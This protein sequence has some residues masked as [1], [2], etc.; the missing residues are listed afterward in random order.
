MRRDIF[1][2]LT[3]ALDTTGHNCF[4]ECFRHSA[5]TRKHSANFFPSVTL[6]KYVSVNC[7]SVTDS[8]SSTFCRALDKGFVEWPECHLV[9]VGIN[10]DWILPV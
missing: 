5:K 7:T 8:L 9:V 6:D 3:H 1:E 10:I 4:V 2:F